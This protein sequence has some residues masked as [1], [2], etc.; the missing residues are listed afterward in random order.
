MSFVTSSI[1]LNDKSSQAMSSGHSTRSRANWYSPRVSTRLLLDNLITLL[2]Y[3]NNKWARPAKLN[4]QTCRTVSA[5]ACEDSA[6]E[7]V[8]VGW[9]SWR[10][11]WMSSP[12]GVRTPLG[13]MPPCSLWAVC[14]LDQSCVR[15]LARATAIISFINHGGDHLPRTDNSHEM[16]E[17]NW[18]K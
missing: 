2:L 17:E 18:E 15:P 14:S 11:S 4:H 1:S 6:W 9:I 16:W 12:E 8:K 5:S 3:L 10:C 7:S 13:K